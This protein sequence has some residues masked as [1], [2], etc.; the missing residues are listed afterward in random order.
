MY[1]HCTYISIIF[2]TYNKHKYTMYI[3]KYIIPS[4]MYDMYYFV[5]R[6]KYNAYISAIF[7]VS[8]GVVG[9]STDYAVFFSTSSSTDNL[10]NMIFLGIY[11]GCVFR[12]ERCNEIF[13]AKSFLCSCG[14]HS[15]TCTAIWILH[16]VGCC[17]RESA[18]RHENITSHRLLFRWTET[19]DLPDSFSPRLW[20][21]SKQKNLFSNITDNV[22]ETDP[23]VCSRKRSP[24]QQQVSAQKINFPREN[25]SDIKFLVGA[26]QWGGGLVGGSN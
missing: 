6:G 12:F 11:F 22:E 20:N 23:Y 25:F 21:I 19:E 18:A 24:P 8:Q 3:C 26:P 2:N 13:S 9:H 16:W 5:R 7:I 14:F 15:D 17:V 10:Y 1:I 4:I